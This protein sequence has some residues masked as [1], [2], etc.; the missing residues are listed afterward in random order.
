MPAS[1]TFYLNLPAVNLKDNDLGISFVVTAM[2]A[3][4]IMDNVDEIREFFAENVS[5]IDR[6]REERNVMKQNRRQELP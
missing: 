2:R 6:E 5:N 1:R 3:K 4:L